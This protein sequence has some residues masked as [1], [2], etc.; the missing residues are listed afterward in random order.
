M[1]PKLALLILVFMT[2]GGCSCDCEDYP[3]YFDITGMNTEVTH[4]ETR[5]GNQQPGEYLLEA[6][7]TV[8]FDK[9]Y[10]YLKPSVSFYGTRNKT[11]SFSFVNSA[12]ACS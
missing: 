4:L 2:G 1:K 10:I 8:E 9:I 11:I 5:L 7:A 12:Y 3:D 6:S